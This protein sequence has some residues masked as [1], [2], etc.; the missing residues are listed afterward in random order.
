MMGNRGVK[1]ILQ[2]YSM[3]VSLRFVS[4]GSGGGALKSS[5][6]LKLFFF[7]PFSFLLCFLGITFIGSK[8]IL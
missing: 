8:R 3:I 2:V 7:I 6:T 1:S 5:L 4:R